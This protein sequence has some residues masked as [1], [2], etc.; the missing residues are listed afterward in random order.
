VI[1]KPVSRNLAL[2]ATFWRL[3]YAVTW[4]VVALNLF[5]AL[6]LLS[7]AD[8]LPA[9]GAERCGSDAGTVG[10]FRVV[11]PGRGALIRHDVR[12]GRKGM[13]SDELPNLNCFATLACRMAVGSG[14][15][16]I[17]VSEPVMPA[18]APPESIRHPSQVPALA[19]AARPTPL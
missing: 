14:I 2:L 3:I 6:R 5:T 7:G 10:G 1:L 9:F 16:P 18:P 12:Y 8:Y 17:P 19:G 13:N 11:V 4:V 15:Q